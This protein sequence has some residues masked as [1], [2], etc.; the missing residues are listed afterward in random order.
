M[1]V[2]H[3]TSAA[4][5]IL[6]SGWRDGHGTYLT[7]APLKGVW[8]A[9]VSLDENEG[10]SGDA[11][12]VIEL[13]DA[14]FAEYEVVEEGKPYREALVPAVVLNEYRAMTR[15]ITPDELELL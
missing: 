6:A 8:V 2:F 9:D 3:R 11:V 15:L 12:L 5:A 7:G 13:P 10:A 4:D 14:V 1:R